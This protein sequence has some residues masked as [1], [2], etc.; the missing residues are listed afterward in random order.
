MSPLIFNGSA[1]TRETGCLA[2][3]CPQGGGQWAIN[4]ADGFCQ[5]KPPL[6][7]RD[8]NAVLQRLKVGSNK[9]L[10]GLGSTGR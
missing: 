3:A 10:I 7:V 4:G 1:Q 5:S 6:E 8:D 9:T 2:N